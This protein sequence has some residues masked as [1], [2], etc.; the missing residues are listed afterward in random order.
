MGT[1]SRL[2]SIFQMLREVVQATE[3]DPTA[4]LAALEKRK[5]EIENE[6][7]GLRTG[8]RP[9]SYDAT[10]VKERYLQIE[11]SARR[12]LS[13]FRQVEEN[14]RQLDRLARE[15]IAV[16]DKSKGRAIP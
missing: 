6:M 14:F 12:L 1:E 16:S 8:N 4:R 15:K 10:R 5:A 13:D 3:S 9:A 2:L 7:Q 11:D